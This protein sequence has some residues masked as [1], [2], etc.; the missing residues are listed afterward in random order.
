MTWSLGLC[1][2]NYR[3]NWVFFQSHFKEL[4]RLKRWRFQQ[5][6]NNYADLYDGDGDVPD[7]ASFQINLKTGKQTTT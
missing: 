3:C 7:F 2:W 5:L 4:F 1:F 6:I